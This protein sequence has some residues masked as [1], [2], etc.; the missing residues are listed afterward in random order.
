M[1][2]N[3]NEQ[4]LFDYVLGQVDER[5]H[6]QDKVQSIVSGSTEISAAISRIDAELWRY[7]LERSEVTPIFVES[8]RAF[9]LKRTSM[10]NL[11][12][13]LVRLWTE[14]RKRKA[15]PGG[16]GAGPENPA[17]ENCLP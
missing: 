5:H 2:L 1:S 6:W 12:E 9:G 14:P 10:K 17:Q 11:A 3:R 8:A 16:S 4:M 13:L 15:T 7:Y